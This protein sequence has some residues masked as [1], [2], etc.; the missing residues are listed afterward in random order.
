MNIVFSKFECFS[1]IPFRSSNKILY[2]HNS[3]KARLKGYLWHAE[4]STPLQVL[5]SSDCFYTSYICICI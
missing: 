3:I 1:E 5:I 4:G 2:L